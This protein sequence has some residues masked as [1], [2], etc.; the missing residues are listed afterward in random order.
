[1]AIYD[2]YYEQENYFGNAY[3]ELVDYFNGLD[4]NLKIL[5]VG[6]GQGRDSIALGKLGFEVLGID[7]SS[8][9]VAQMNRL[10]KKDDLHVQ[11]I[12]HDLNEFED[13]SSYDIVLFDKM[14]HFYKKDL[15]HEIGLL[16][17]YLKK[18]KKGARLVI[19]LQKSKYRVKI[20]KEEVEKSENVFAIEYE[21]T[22]N[23]SE[24]N[25]IFYMISLKK[26]E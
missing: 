22:F 7:V 23:Y 24:F 6:C 11:G 8:V 19:V 12:V 25:S 15:E 21:N 13:I 2:K 9:G 4:K 17:K 26:N 20:I 18:I 5:D 1:M 16:N 10:A 3:P 14:F